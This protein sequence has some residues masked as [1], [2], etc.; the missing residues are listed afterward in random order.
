MRLTAIRAK[1]FGIV[2]DADNIDS[3]S[4]PLS[5]VTNLSLSLFSSP[6]PLAI[7]MTPSLVRFEFDSTISFLAFF[8]LQDLSLCICIIFSSFMSAA[9]ATLPPFPY[10]RPHYIADYLAMYI[11]S[12]C[13]EE[14][15]ER[16]SRGDSWGHF[17]DVAR[18]IAARISSLRPNTIPMYHSLRRTSYCSYPISLIVSPQYLGYFYFELSGCFIAVLPWWVNASN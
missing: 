13:I 1:Y 18:R 9:I 8:H 6:L 10:V 5:H 15:W 11:V 16:G 14:E 12:F 17:I 2:T 7:E 3:F 4:G